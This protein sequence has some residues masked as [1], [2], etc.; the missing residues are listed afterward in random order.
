MRLWSLHPRQLD[1]QGL[2]ALWREGLLALAVVRGKTR[3]YRHH[4]QLAR[5]WDCRNPVRALEAY[6]RVVL[7]E[8]QARGFN[9]DSAK[10]GRGRA[11]SRLT[12]ARG[13]LEYEWRHLLRKLHRRD[14]A[15]WAKQR[16]AA[17]EAHPTFAVV[18]GPMAVWER[19]R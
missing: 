13:Q 14:R 10:L 9:F 3:G 1:A 11:R 18:S 2:V 16:K 17:P 7:A 12:V 4:P 8:A 6:L 19:P 5:F 15:R